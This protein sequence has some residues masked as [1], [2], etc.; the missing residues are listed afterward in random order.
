[1]G[2]EQSEGLWALIITSGGKFI[3]EIDSTKDEMTELMANAGFIT[4]KNAYEV[5]VNLI[6]IPT[7]NGIMMQ[8]E[9][10][11]TPLIMTLHGAPLHVKP[12]AV[13]FFDEMHDLDAAGYKRLAGDADKAA[14]KARA[15]IAG[16]TTAG[17]PLKKE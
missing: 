3:G 17:G 8:R 6:P 14:V 7:P 5:S 11:C 13:Q 4:L 1:M 12:V 2:D 9:V 10:G 16:I 15:A